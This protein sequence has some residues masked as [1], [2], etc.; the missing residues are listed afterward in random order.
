MGVLGS[1]AFPGRLPGAASVAVVGGLLAVSASGFL[2][3][4]MRRPRVAYAGDDVLFFL[5]QRDAIRVPLLVVEAFFLGQGDHSVPGL[6]RESTYATYLIA[7][8]DQ[9]KTEWASRQCN[10]RLGKWC[11]GYIRINGAWTEPLTLDTV[12]RVNRLLHEAKQLPQ[13]QR[14]RPGSKQEHI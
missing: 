8:L 5:T 6:P 13:E 11:D 7:R 14:T 1:L 3:W 4:R 10:P 2:G 12:G 9:R